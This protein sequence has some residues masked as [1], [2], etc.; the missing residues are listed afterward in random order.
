MEIEFSF[1]SVVQ[2]HFRLLSSRTR[3]YRELE[4]S[5]ISLQ[6]LNHLFIY[7]LLIKA[8]SGLGCMR[9]HVESLDN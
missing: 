1:S 4:S 2:T 6:I 3:T 5:C 7:S 8:I 9:R